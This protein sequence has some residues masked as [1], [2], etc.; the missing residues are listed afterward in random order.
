MLAVYLSYE[1]TY[2]QL[3]HRRFQGPNA[4]FC[5]TAQLVVGNI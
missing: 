3:P 4:D 5:I 1:V 2:L